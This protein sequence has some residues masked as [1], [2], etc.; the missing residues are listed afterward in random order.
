MGIY[1]PS[2]RVRLTDADSTIRS[3]THWI[4]MAFSRRAAAVSGQN[5]I[6]EGA[7]SSKEAR[8]AVRAM[9]WASRRGGEDLAVT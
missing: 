7:G 4:Q 5:D 3:K 1:P 2:D 6:G 9:G 8:Q